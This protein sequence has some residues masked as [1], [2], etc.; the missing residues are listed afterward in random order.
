MANWYATYFIAFSGFCRSRAQ[1]SGARIVA[2]VYITLPFESCFEVVYRAMILI[3][4]KRTVSL[5]RF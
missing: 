4:R 3:I 2:N 5:S 1:F